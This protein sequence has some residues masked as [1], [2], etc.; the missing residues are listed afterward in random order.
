MSAPVGLDEHPRVRTLSVPEPAATVSAV[1]QPLMTVGL[2][3]ILCAVAFTADGGLQ[4][5]RTTPVEIGLILGGGLAVAGAILLAPRR[6][7]LWGVTPLVLMIALAVLT[8]LSLTWAASPS[9]AYLEANRT[10]AYLAVFAGAAALANAAPDRWGTVVGAITL[11]AVAISAYA[12]L[13]KIAPGPLNPDETFARL[14]EPF[15]YWNSVGLAA[16]LGV[17]GVL[18][19]GT[20]RTGHQTLNALAY[21]ALGLLLLTILLAYSRGALLAALVGTGLWIVMVRPRRLRAAALLLAGVAGGGATAAWTFSQ[22]ALSGDRVPLDLREQAGLQLGLLVL[23]MIVVLALVGLT[24]GFFAE[25]RTPS[26][27]ARRQIGVA[28]LAGL[29]LVPIAVVGQMALSDAGLGGTISHHWN[30]LTDP[31]AALP[32]NDPSRLTAAGSVR[33]RYWDE[34]LRIFADNPGVGVGAGG[35]ATVRKRYRTADGAVRQAHGYVV[36]TLSDLGLAGAAVSLA[37]LAAWLASAA[38][39]TGF[40]LR[41]RRRPAAVAVHEY[42]PER[43]G[44]ITLVAVVA[45]FGVH[46][47]IDWTWLVP[48]NAAVALLAAG[49]VAGRGPLGREAARGVPAGVVERLRAGLRQAPRA[50][51]AAGIV[52]A[53][54]IGAWTAWQPLRSDKLAQ[55]SL[56]TLERGDVDAARSQAQR[57]HDANPLALDPLFKLATIEQRAP[58]RQLQAKA[59]LEQAVR[60]QPLNPEP[61]IALAQYDLDSGDAKAAET[62]SRRAVYLDP[63]SSRP[64]GVFLDARQQIAATRASTK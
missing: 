17:P 8:A 48:G 64:L 13:T 35:Y 4:I 11:S 40:S 21:P 37:L 62:A 27:R 63:R 56:V 53:A 58:D 52:V 42:S 45:V 12:V 16:A 9:D 44:L 57:A 1:A 59:A 7:R 46:S 47:T 18:W 3:A 26:P 31:D 38:A 41:R 39:A 20:R 2:A 22:S 14:R 49:W 29:A 34:A 51:W 55:E 36:Q 43:I 54:L 32:V 61:W 6:P 28:L 23:A 30:S 25:V 10:F 19:L 15:D 33:A 24:V 50:L 60:M 5:E